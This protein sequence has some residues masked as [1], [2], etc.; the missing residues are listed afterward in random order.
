MAI[1]SKGKEAA[2]AL[3]HRHGLGTGPVDPFEA[4]RREGVEVFIQAFENNGLEGAF[5]RRDGR[6]FVFVNGQSWLTRRRMTAAHELG[7]YLLEPAED[8]DEIYE[9]D[10][11]SAPNGDPGE[12]EAYRFA[13]Y[14]LMDE[15]GVRALVTDIRDAEKRVAAVASEFNVSPEVAAIHLEELGLVTSAVKARIT[16]ELRSGLLKPSALLKRHGFS[17]AW[18]EPEALKLDPGHKVRAMDAYEAGNMQLA[19]LADALVTTPEDA[20]RQL[21]AA[22]IEV[23]EE[24]ASLA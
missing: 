18:S 22:G 20:A 8:G 19:G 9:G 6:A 7:H 12:W 13:R 1:R 2:E 3:R 23:R 15:Q 10:V 21:R 24:E 5:V 16:R 17:M 11:S 4:L 14:F